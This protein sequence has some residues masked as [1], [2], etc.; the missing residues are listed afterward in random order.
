MT[1]IMENNS[2]GEVGVGKKAG[3][4]G[5]RGN[6]SRVRLRCVTVAIMTGPFE[7]VPCQDN[8]KA[9]GLTIKKP[10]N[11]TASGL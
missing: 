5:I 10:R 3:L 8:R 4:G 7:V 11:L 1:T 9:T 2:G 6:D